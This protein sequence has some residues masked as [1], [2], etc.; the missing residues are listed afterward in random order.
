MNDKRKEE[1]AKVKALKKLGKQQKGLT[2]IEASMQSSD[3]N[4]KNE[5]KKFREYRKP[6][7]LDKL[8]FLLP[9]NTNEEWSKAAMIL[10]LVAANQISLKD[11]P[12]HLND[13][14]NLK[15][16]QRQ[17]V[18]HLG[19]DTWEEFEEAFPNHHQREALETLMKDLGKFTPSPHC[20][21]G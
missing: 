11:A 9:C 3:M 16:L 1:S 19:L 5:L 12:G 8:K 2:P 18:L 13:Y 20:V 17:L 10:R 6:L 7:T 15:R 4:L 21:F 14:M